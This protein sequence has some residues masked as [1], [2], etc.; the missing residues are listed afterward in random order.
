MT[1]YDPGGVIIFLALGWSGGALFNH[2]E[3]GL[4]VMALFIALIPVE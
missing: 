2:P 1:E 3:A 4:F